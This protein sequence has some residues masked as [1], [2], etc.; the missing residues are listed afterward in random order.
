MYYYEI[1]SSISKKKKFSWHWNAKYLDWMSLLRIISI[2][3][4]SVYSEYQN[5]KPIIVNKQVES[6]KRIQKSS[7]NHSI[8]MACWFLLLQSTSKEYSYS[9]FKH[10]L[11]CDK[12]KALIVH[13][14]I[15]KLPVAHETACV[16]DVKQNLALLRRI[17][18]SIDAGT[19]QKWIFR[20]NFDCRGATKNFWEMLIVAITLWKKSTM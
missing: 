7:H 8:S 13:L 1:R 6:E 4:V 9:H 11:H 10:W 5:L 18:Q 14:Q 2:S 12:A 20:L 19:V 17:K 3:K 15:V 16:V